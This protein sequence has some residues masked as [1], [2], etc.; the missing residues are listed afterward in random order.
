MIGAEPYLAVNMGSGTVQEASKWVQYVNNRNGSGNLTDLR[1]Q[2]GR[3]TPWHVK[4]WGGVE[5]SHGIV[6]DI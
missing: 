2:N 3:T 6:V 4:Y 1:M 5:M